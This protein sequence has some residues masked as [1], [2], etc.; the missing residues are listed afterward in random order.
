MEFIIGLLIG[1]VIT[2]YITVH[3]GKKSLPQL[4]KMLTDYELKIAQTKASIEVLE[5][6]GGKTK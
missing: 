4:K 6:Q 1:A 2:W 5:K 3:P